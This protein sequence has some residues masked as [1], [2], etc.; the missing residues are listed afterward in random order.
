VSPGGPKRM[1]FKG[2]HREI[3]REHDNWVEFAKGRVQQC[4]RL[5]WP[6]ISK[7]ENLCKYRE[8]IQFHKTTEFINQKN[9]YND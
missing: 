5:K 8:I 3:V 9:K 7:T 2:D 6:R 1:M 4:S